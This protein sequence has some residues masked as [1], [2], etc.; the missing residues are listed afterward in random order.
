MLDQQSGLQTPHQAGLAVGRVFD[1][2][3]CFTKAAILGRSPFGSPDLPNFDSP[4]RAGDAGTDLPT[5][6]DDPAH[7]GDQPGGRVQHT[8]HRL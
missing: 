4:L 3:G 8:P 7:V 6:E 2:M 1:S 5:Q